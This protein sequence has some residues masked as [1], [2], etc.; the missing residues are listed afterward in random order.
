MSKRATGSSWLQLTHS[1]PANGDIQHRD[2]R[3]NTETDNGNHVGIAL[4]LGIVT[5]ILC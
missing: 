5:A 1:F 4:E 3:D 2:G